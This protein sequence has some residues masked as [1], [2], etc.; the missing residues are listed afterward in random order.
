MADQLGAGLDDAHAV[1]FDTV[2]DLQVGH[3]EFLEQLVL[4]GLVIAAHGLVELH[5][6]P[7]DEIEDGRGVDGRTQ[8]LVGGRIDLGR[9]QSAQIGE[10]ITHLHEDGGHGLD[11][12]QAV[13][14]AHQVGA[15]LGQDGQGFRREARAV[16]VVDDDAE[17]HALADLLHMGD[18]AF[19]AGF[20]QV[21]RHQQNAV[22]TQSFSLLG[23]GDGVAGGAA[24]A[25]DD[26]HLATAGIHGGLDDLAVF[27]AI[28]RE[29]FA[30][31]TSGEQGTGA[32]GSQ[33]FKA[34]G[35]TLGI[36]VALGIEVRHGEGQQAGTHHVFE[37]LGCHGNP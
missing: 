2:A 4:C 29:V 18:Q 20:G 33:P 14:E 3:E 21:M 37:V 8:S 24:S 31:A 36:E 17:L 5:R 11:I 6:R 12:A 10:A 16:A 28:Q 9:G 34:C 26:G 1:A 22:G 27:L 15:A 7:G 13:L 30:G 19:L 23:M 32:I 25:G 35:I